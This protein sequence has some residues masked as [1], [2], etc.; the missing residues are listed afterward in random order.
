[1]DYI[2]QYYDELVAAIIRPPRAEYDLSELGAP[3]AR[4]DGK[5]F[6]R[7]DFELKNQRGLTL[8]CSQFVGARHYQR[9]PV[10]IYC[11]GNAGCRV[12]AL[13]VCKLLLPMGISVVCF[14]F[15]GSGLSEGEYVSLGYYEKDDL[16]CVVDYLR[17]NNS[18]TRI[19]LW[20]RSM[21]AVTSLMFGVL[22][23]SIACLVLDSPFSSLKTL[24]N[25]L[26]GKLEQKIPKSIVNVA[27]KMLKKT[28]DK[29]AHFNIE[30]LEPIKHASSCFIPALF[31]HAESDDFVS[32]SHS[33]AISQKYCGDYNRITFEG[34]HN[35]QRPQFFYDSAAIWF[36]NN[37]L[38]ESD[39]NEDNPIVFEPG[40]EPP[41]LQKNQT[42]T[43]T[44]PKIIQIDAIPEDEDEQ[45]KLALAMSLM[46]VQKQES[47]ANDSV[48]TQEST[49]KPKN[50]RRESTEKSKKLRESREATEKDSAKLRESVEKSKSEPSEKVSKKPKKEKKKTDKKVKKNHS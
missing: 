44:P 49:E 22:D 35:S 46:E 25:E 12:D 7:K 10:V 45:L 32:P 24:S 9:M 47:Q 42:A 11:H 17:K 38:V 29:K 8:Q 2:N 4:L 33:L 3:V 13:D 21:G 15:A 23:P 19:G 36:S 18:T 14:D 34:D 43:V 30:K 39:F 28:I 20:G 37:L 31:A 27:F 1:M 16:A 5:V 26:V 48:K 41:G 50:K 40:F 6:V